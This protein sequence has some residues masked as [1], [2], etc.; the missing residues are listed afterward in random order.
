MK[1]SPGVLALV[2]SGEYSLQ[3]QEFESELLQSARSRGKRNT[4][5]QIPTASSHEGP[6]R[7]R[8]WQELGQ[9][10]AERIGS[11]CIYLPI[12]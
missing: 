6:A 4:Y 1:A 11:E 8:H 9:A 5:I 10:Q 7:R 2:G 12:H 3:M